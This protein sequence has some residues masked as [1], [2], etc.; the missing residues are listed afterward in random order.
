MFS[1]AFCYRCV[2]AEQNSSLESKS[3]KAAD[4]VF[5]WWS[6]LLVVTHSSGDSLCWRRG[7]A[8]QAV[9]PGSKN[10][11]VSKEIFQVKQASES[12]SAEYFTFS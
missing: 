5:G 12:K 9:E 10:C 7:L 4:V 6:R 11:S 1:K 3:M 2:G 8:A